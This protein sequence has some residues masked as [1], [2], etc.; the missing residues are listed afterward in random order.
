[1][2][3]ID[4]LQSESSPTWASERGSPPAGREHHPG[5]LFGPYKSTRGKRAK[6]CILVV[7]PP[8]T[9]RP[10][11]ESSRW[12]P[13]STTLP[14]LP[15]TCSRPPHLHL[16]GQ[17]YGACRAEWQ[18]LRPT[19]T[20][21]NM[22][23][24]LCLVWWSMTKVCCPRRPLKRRVEDNISPLNPFSHVLAPKRLH[25]RPSLQDSNYRSLYSSPTPEIRIISC[26]MGQRTAQLC[27]RLPQVRL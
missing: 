8:E 18:T 27:L 12:L 19:G 11:L 16:R 22:S 10:A 20:P 2:L 23:S 25:R 5:P 1:M 26:P 3:V 21:G 17:P 24:R 13:A 4:P 15:L 7:K 14:S 6:L 9:C